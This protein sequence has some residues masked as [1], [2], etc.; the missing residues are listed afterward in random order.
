[1]REKDIKKIFDTYC[2]SSEKAGKAEV[3]SERV[4]ASVMEKI[5]MSAAESFYTDSQEEEPVKPVFVTV[6]KKKRNG[7]A[8]KI[9]A[10]AGAAA[11]LGAVV[12]SMGLFGVNGLKTLLLQ[13]SADKNVPAETAAA[14]QISDGQ[15]IGWGIPGEGE[16]MELVFLDG[17]RL[18]YDDAS[19]PPYGFS[20]ADRKKIIPFLYEKDDRLYFVTTKRGQEVKEDITDK[21]SSDD[22]Y[23]FTYNNPDNIANPTHFVIIG[24]DV[25]SGEY[26]YI[27]IYRIS[28]STELWGWEANFSKGTF[29]FHEA[30]S[31]PEKS[32]KKWIY[33]G[34]KEAAEKY[35]RS[36]DVISRGIGYYERYV[37]FKYKDFYQYGEIKNLNLLPCLQLT[38]LN[39]RRVVM[40]PGDSNNG[41][42]S[43]GLYYYED[44]NNLSPVLY[45]ENGR[46]Y[47]TVNND[48]KE[49]NE[50]ITDK[51]NPD[52]C[53]IYTYNNTDNTVNQT[54]YV[55]VCGD[56]SKH[57]Y[58]YWEVYQIHKAEDKW[59]YDEWD[60]YGQYF[61]N[62]KY[63]EKEW[64]I[65]AKKVMKKEYGID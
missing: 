4:K 59:D 41:P 48:G 60:W 46:V 22:F 36:A 55:I 17:V 50:D 27:E 57:E 14:T 23:L 3:S 34:V 35:G 52:D 28:N 40:V 43:N 11:C 37:D 16:S 9:A 53:Y 30:I 29:D 26:G 61:G 47:F 39:G 21:I 64:F 7:A 1:M 32:G 54:H 51:I 49:I 33:K 19:Y 31:D 12:L 24:G 10:W 6:T 45:E 18:M 42:I 20:A 62:G 13:N 58:G 15:N 2:G 56:L 8:I 44:A 25:S 5:G 63:T 65:N 38:F